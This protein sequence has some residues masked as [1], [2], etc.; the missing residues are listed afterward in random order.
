MQS[1]YV[2]KNKSFDFAYITRLHFYWFLRYLKILFNPKL[3][4][5]V[6][7]SFDG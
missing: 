4:A 2:S 6:F 3:T 5:S 1:S 7:A